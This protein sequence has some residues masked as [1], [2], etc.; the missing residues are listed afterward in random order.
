[1]PVGSATE[2][3]STMVVTSKKDG[4]PRRTVDFQPLNSQCLQ[5]THHQGS[6]FHLAMQVPAGAF[7]TVLDAVDG[8]H[9]VE[10]D[11]ESQPLTTFITEWGRYMYKRM[12]QGYLASGDAY[13]SRYDQIIGDVPRKVKIV[14]DTLLWDFS[15]EKAF[16]HTFDYLSLCYQNGVVIIE[17]KFKFC[18]KDVHFAGLSMTTT[19]VAP[20]LTM[21][22]AI[23]NFPTPSNLTDARSWFGLVNQV[24]WADSLGPVMQPFRELVKSNSEFSWTQTLQD[25]FDDSKKQIVKLVEEG[26]STFDVNRVTCL[27]PD[28]SKTGMGFLLLQKYCSCPLTKAPVCCPDGWHLVFAGSRFCNDAESGY[29]PIEGEA[30]AIA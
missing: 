16:Y 12:P 11:E 17:S 20:S 28:W 9:S 7:K 23:T 10:L 30:A 3:C 21:L 24:A 8:Y 25:A 19:G 29:A 1:M 18:E 13:T 5:E 4:R 2:W 6:P 22:S 27:S 26:V 14:D 15:V